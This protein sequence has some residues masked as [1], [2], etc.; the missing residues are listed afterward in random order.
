MPQDILQ[1]EHFMHVLQ[2]TPRYSPNLGGVETVVQKISE[3]LIEKGID[4]TV[5]TVDLAKGLPKEQMINGVIVKRFAPIYD[6]P[7]YLPEPKFIEHMR[8][9]KIDIIHVHNIHILLPLLASLFKQRN[10]RLV[11]QPH[12]HRF[13]QTPFR[14]CLL[15][16]YNKLTS[17]FI[18]SR[19]D[20]IIANSIYEKT[21]LQQDFPE[22][23]N[24]ILIP[25]GLD[26]LEM[27]HMR[28]NPAK[29]ARILYVGALKGYKNVD[30]ILNGFSW[31][32][33]RK[34]A[35]PVKLIV[36]GGGP[37]YSSLVAKAHELRIDSL[38]EWKNN[39]SREQI[40]AEYA[41]ASALVLL[42]R[43]ES[44]SRV[45][46]EA[47]LIGVPLVVLNYGA[48]ASLV[49]AGLA[50]GVNS[51]DEEEI[52]QALLR[53]M[54]RRPF[55]TQSRLNSFLDWGEYVRR[56]VE[57]YRRSLKEDQRQLFKK[58]TSENGC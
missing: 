10:E 38:V 39:L 2:V 1:E 35:E 24:I 58:Y 13:G 30:K 23:R 53:A 29:P 55:K 43:L 32:A 56:I 44:F 20:A 52:A 14:D 17:R 51:F 54:K 49:R 6:D 5:Y 27:G 9:E 34:G 11:I 50:E 33:T 46:N 45:V 31:L 22:C 36:V 42:S 26:T 3:I 48:L 25:E 28:R 41:R 7:L 40:L 19:T 12:Y 21:I 18:F 37:E 47:L 4:V 8:Q 15:Q 16:L 57:I